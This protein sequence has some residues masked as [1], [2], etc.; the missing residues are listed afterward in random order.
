MLNKKDI[1]IELEKEWVAVKKWKED[2][3]Y[4]TADMTKMDEKIKAWYMEEGAS[5]LQRRRAMAAMKESS[6][7]EEPHPTPVWDEPTFI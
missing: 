3:V 7:M 6:S 5:I 4:M 2:F 1:K